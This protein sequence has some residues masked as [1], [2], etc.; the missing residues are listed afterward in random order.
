MD[1]GLIQFYTSM[2]PF[3][4]DVTGIAFVFGGKKVSS[5]KEES[6]KT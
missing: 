6:E 1:K 2:S 3:T 4:A 5:G